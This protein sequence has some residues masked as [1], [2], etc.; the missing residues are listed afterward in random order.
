MSSGDEFDKSCAQDA[1]LP[2]RSAQS[3]APRLVHRA[4]RDDARARAGCPP[5]EKCKYIRPNLFLLLTE[6][7]VIIEPDS[8]RGS[9]IWCILIV[10]TAF[11][12][13]GCGAG[14]GTGERRSKGLVGSQG[15]GVRVL[16]VANEFTCALSCK[17]GTFEASTVV[18]GS[19]T[20]RS[21]EALCADVSLSGASRA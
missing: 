13:C 18:G 20:F 11:A 8:C 16:S 5:G 9:P 21:E 17:A 12:G 14:R 2:Y 1:I 19:V 6:K 7:K 3:A 15:E 10:V 4:G